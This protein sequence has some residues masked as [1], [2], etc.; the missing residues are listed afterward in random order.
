MSF[1]SLS[2]AS[3]TCNQIDLDSDDDTVTG[4]TVGVVKTEPVK[5]EPVQ[6]VKTEPVKTEPAD[7]SSGKVGSETSTK[8]IHRMMKCL[9]SFSGQNQQLRGTGT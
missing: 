4:D 1:P 7:T 8:K 3:S 2:L 9:N 6:H 5:T